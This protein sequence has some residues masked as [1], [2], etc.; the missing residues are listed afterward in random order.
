MLTAIELKSLEIQPKINDISLSVLQEFYE[1]FLNPYTYKYTIISKD[2]SWEISLKFKKENFCHLLGIESVV[3]QSVKFSERQ[4]Y[5]GKK[6]WQ[7]IKDG[8]IDIKH[9]KQISKKKF[10]SIKAKYVYFYLIPNLIEKP[11][12]VKYDRSKVNPPT[13]IECEL[14]FY[15]KFNNA[16][17]H[18][19]LDKDEKGQQENIYIPRTFFVE[20]LGKN[21]T[22]DIYINNQE[23][24]SVIKK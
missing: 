16:I 10:Q 1:I 5:R 12:A 19:G 22:K 2:S 15:S 13:Q 6:G 20:K 21:T 4:N 8:K 17:I 18:L 14:L 24:I 7:N 23:H 3:K 9:L 11:L